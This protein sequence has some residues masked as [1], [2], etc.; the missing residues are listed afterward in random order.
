MRLSKLTYFVFVIVL[1]VMSLSVTVFRGDTGSAT[2][3][4]NVRATRATYQDRTDRYPVVHDDEPEPPDP[5]KRAK[6]KQQKRRFDKDAPF[7]TRPGPQDQEIAFRPEWQFDFPGLPV[8]Q[9]D[10]IV[11]GQVQRS[12]AHRSQNK[13]NVFSNFLVT[14]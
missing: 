7:F 13:K 4:Q 5:V 10:V 2:G 8:A 9:S 11:V 6:L 14:V 1:T 12:E 3:Q